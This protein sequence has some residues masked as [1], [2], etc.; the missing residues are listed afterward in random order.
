M[1]LVVARASTRFELGELREA[2][3]IAYSGAEELGRSGGRSR[4]APCCA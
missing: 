4:R 3:R 1:R 2:Y